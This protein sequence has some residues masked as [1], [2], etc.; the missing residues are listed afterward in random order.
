MA[1]LRLYLSLH[2]DTKGRK[3]QGKLHRPVQSVFDISLIF[4]SMA[5]AGSFSHLVLQVGLTKERKKGAAN[6]G[7]CGIFPS[8][9]TSCTIQEPE[10]LSA[11]ASVGLGGV[12]Q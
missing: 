12:A 8:I 2:T 11:A 5:S 4:I 9:N 3:G 7:I 10:Q 6:L 1:F